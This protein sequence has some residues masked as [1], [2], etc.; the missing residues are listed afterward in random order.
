MGGFLGFVLAVI[1]ASIIVK[2]FGNVIADVSESAIKKC[3]TWLGNT[4][5]EDDNKRKE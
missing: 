2:R 4:L 3:F 1:I 5:R